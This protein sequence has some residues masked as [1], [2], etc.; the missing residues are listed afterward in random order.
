MA[1]RI[2]GHHV[3]ISDQFRSYIESK[4]PRIEKYTDQIQQ[5]EIVLEDDGPDTLAEFRLKAG[6]MEVN[7]KH[8][9]HDATKAIDLLIDKAER[10]LK[11]Q[12]D[13]IKGRNKHATAS[14]HDSKRANFS[15]DA[16]P[17]PLIET[18][19]PTLGEAASANGN[20]NGNGNGA[21]RSG[22]DMPIMHEKL[23]VRIFP[24]PKSPAGPMSVQ[25]AAEELYF[26]DENF[27][28]FTDEDSDELSIIYRRKDGNFAVM[29]AN[30]NA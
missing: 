19:G 20:G 25:E 28:C 16:D 3:N 29:H 9:D 26:R 23:S 12:H 6:Q 4:V 27:L 5:L 14:A 24:S 2:Y 7:V 18:E 22:R 30:G 13:M 15:P 8:R 11:K 17:V 21:D 10:A 1:V